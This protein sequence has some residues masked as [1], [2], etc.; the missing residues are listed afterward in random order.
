MAFSVFGFPF[1][2][3]Q[4]WSSWSRGRSEWG[5]ALYLLLAGGGGGL[6]GWVPAFFT[7][8]H[9]TDND[10]VNGVIYGVG[11]ALALRADFKGQSKKLAAEETR[12]IKSFL[13]AG[14]DWTIQRMDAKTRRA[15]DNWLSNLDD[16][17]LIVTTYRLMAH[18]K[19]QPSKVMPDKMKTITIKPLNEYM[20]ILADQSDPLKRAEA[21]SQLEKFC[22]D[23]FVA[24][25]IAK[26][27]TTTLTP[28]ATI[29]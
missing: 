26:P 21:R 28:A 23:Y 2:Q 17:A 8:A 14:I 27:A 18:V 7:H 15:A 25:H 13:R 22:S 5:F 12:D 9:P 10:V 19:S 1:L 29:R 4:C 24:Q 16:M 3:R 6:L 11:G 20:E